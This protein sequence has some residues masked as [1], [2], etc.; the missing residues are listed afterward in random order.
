MMLYNPQGGGAALADPLVRR[1]KAR[2]SP[3]RLARQAAL[4]EAAGF[5][6]GVSVTSPQ[7]NQILAK[8]PADASRATRQA[9]ED[10]GFEVCYTPTRNDTDHHTVIFPK[11]LT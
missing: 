1:G 3:A 4:A 11:P 8:D 5:G 9:L 10:A 7:A 2:E 6:H